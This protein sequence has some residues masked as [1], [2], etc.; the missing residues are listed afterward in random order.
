[1]KQV[2]E[3]VTSCIPQNPNVQRNDF[4]HAALSGHKDDLSSKMIF[5]VDYKYWIS[6]YFIWSNSILLFICSVNHDI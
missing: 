2:S 5:Y 6:A 4:S 3:L 1:M